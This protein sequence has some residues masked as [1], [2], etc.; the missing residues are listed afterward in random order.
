MSGSTTPK[1]QE[2][3]AKGV[4]AAATQTKNKAKAFKTA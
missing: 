1:D 4:I 3:F 2:N